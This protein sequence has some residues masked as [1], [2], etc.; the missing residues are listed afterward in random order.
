MQTP[1]GTTQ[2]PTTARESALYQSGFEAGR[3]ACKQELAAEL[4][5]AGLAFDAF[6]RTCVSIR[7]ALAGL[8]EQMIDEQFGKKHRG[9]MQAMLQAAQLT[10]TLRGS[11]HAAH[12]DIQAKA[13]QA[14]D[15]EKHSR[16]AFNEAIARVHSLTKKPGLL[17]RLANAARG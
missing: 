10:E 14:H 6:Q 3:A 7:T 15:D 5:A 16:V 2:V 17:Q 12:A 13:K 1:A 9:M 4:G 11:I 8:H